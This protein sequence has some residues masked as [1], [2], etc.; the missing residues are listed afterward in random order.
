MPRNFLRLLTLAAA[1][2]CA[3]AAH[4]AGWVDSGPLSPADRVATQPQAVITPG[5]ERVIAWVQNLQNGFSAE[6][7]SVRAAPPGGDFGPTQTF[8]GQVDGPRLAVAPDGTVALAWV[9]FSTRTVHIARRAPG[10]ASFVDATPLT[11]PGGETP[12]NVHL[13]FSGTD[14]IVSFESFVSQTATSIWAAR[15]A[16]GSGGVEIVPGTALGGAIDHQSNAQGQPQV[17]LDGSDLAVDNGQVYVSWQQENEGTTNANGVTITDGFTAVKYAKRLPG[18][19]FGAPVVLDTLFSNSNFAPTATPR[20]AAGGGHTYVVWLRRS[21]QPV[22]NYED[23]AT[24]G[25]PLTI[26]TDPFFDDLLVGADGSGALIVAGQADP[27][28]SDNPA[29]S[30]AIVP[31]GTAPG[32]AVRLTPAGI[33]RQLDALAVASDGTALLLPDRVS[34]S[35]TATLQAEASLRPAGGAFGA[36]EDVSGLQDGVRDA[37]QSAGAAVAPGGRALALWSAADHS[38]TANQRL[39]V[40]EFD[41]TP[42]AFGA[43]TVPAT[44]TVGQRVAVSATASDALSATTV[45]WD[46]GDGSQADGDSVS[47]VFGEPGT[48]TVTVTATDAAGN[49]VTQTR[50]IA[51]AP[52]PTPTPTGTPV[53]RTAPVISGVSVS[54]ARFRVGAPAT[55]QIAAGRRKARRAPVGTVFRLT[56]SEHATLVIAIRQR[57]RGGSVLRGTLVRTRTGPGAAAI[58]FSGRIGRTALAAGSYTATLTAIDGAGNRSAPR[59]VTF[60]IATR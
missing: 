55:A 15:L 51:V 46:F 53:D 11:V 30:A 44:A 4:A 32:P 29:V 36:P 39:H 52:A 5:G 49:S 7:I 16:A 57:N 38:G 25:A 48:S 3:P 23:V 40:S 42:P 43:I 58:A 18:G 60:T 6:N 24:G 59:L 34:S 47:H 22:V 31:A 41:A 14:A 8:S 26:P 33:G 28:G 12:F 13:A 9:D 20:I 50:V 27:P 10:Q 37:P 54:H 1:L 19:Q 35:F 56:L 2:S 45:T 21:D 17:F